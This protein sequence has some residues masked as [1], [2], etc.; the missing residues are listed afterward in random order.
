MSGGDWRSCSNS[1]CL[2]D[3]RLGCG[4]SMKGARQFFGVVH[5]VEKCKD[6]AEL[7]YG[8]GWNASRVVF[9]TELFQSLVNEAPNFHLIDCSL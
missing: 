8:V 9:F 2:Y 4:L 5:V 3:H 6:L 7:V 1:M